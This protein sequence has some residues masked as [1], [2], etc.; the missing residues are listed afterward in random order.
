MEP[1]AALLDGP[2]AQRAF[3]LRARFEGH[4]AIGVEDRAALTVVVAAHGH[5]VVRIAGEE[6]RISA[7]DVILLRGPRPY[8]VGDDPRTPIGIRILPGQVCVDPDGSLLDASM[9]LGV[10]TWGNTRS[11][12]ATTLLIGT[13]ERETSVGAHVLAHL[14]PA[15][16]LRDARGPAV[17][18]LA[19]E[20]T[21]DGPGQDA[22]LDRLL[23][24]VLIQSLRTV[25]ASAPLPGGPGAGADPAVARALGLMHQHPS[26]PWTV[27]ALASQ[28]GLSRAAFARR[29]AA[30]TGQPPLAYLTRWRL[31]L[32]ADLLAG[33][34]LTLDAVAA[35]VGYSTGFALSVAFKRDRGVSPSRYRAQAA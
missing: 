4:W 26:R 9:D 2:R 19:A 23:D 8:I 21:Q 10:R 24:L 6:H 35:R 33:T 5:A 27:A 28:A 3:V 22:V 25:F 13:Y 34:D 12:E 1:L 32:A 17:E 18:M 20:L 15:S 14:P 29:F 11:P 7:G 31:C 16:L 30:R